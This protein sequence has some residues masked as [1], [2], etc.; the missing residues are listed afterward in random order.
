MSVPIDQRKVI[1]CVKN[2]NHAAGGGAYNFAEVLIALAEL[3]GKTIVVHAKHKIQ[4]EELQKIVNDHISKTI[5]IIEQA[6][7]KPL[8]S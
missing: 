3:A 4:A 8:D 2:L 1:E 6:R 5:A 7:Q